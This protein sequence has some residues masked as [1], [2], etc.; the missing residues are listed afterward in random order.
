MNDAPVI[1]ARAPVRCS[2]SIMI[3]VAP[4][5]VWAVLTD[6]ARWAD[7][8]PRIHMAR[9]AGPLAPGGIIHWQID[10][11]RIASRLTHADPPTRLAWAGSDGESEGIHVWSLVP[12]GGRTRLVNA[13]SFDGPAARADPAAF[14]KH[15]VE[16]LEQWNLCLKRQVEGAAG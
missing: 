9:L 1:D 12:E 5:A 13:E 7:W 4:S 3:D 2:P 14:T 11:M 6:V 15:L 8:M 16:A 10:D